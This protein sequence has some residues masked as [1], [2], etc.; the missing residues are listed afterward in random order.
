MAT[1]PETLPAPVRDGLSIEFGDNSLSRK[2]Q[3][4]RTEFVRFGS[5]APDR[6]TMKIRLIGNKFD[7]F[8]SFFN[9]DLNRGTNWFSASWITDELGYFDHKGKIVGYPQEQVSGRN[10][11]GMAYK[12]V[13]FEL[14]IKPSAN[15]PA[16]DTVWG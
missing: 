15:C 7:T 12:D 6:F 10:G 2:C 8:R 1:W 13:T 3:S 11:Y 16:D 9:N 5:G 14:I 4:G